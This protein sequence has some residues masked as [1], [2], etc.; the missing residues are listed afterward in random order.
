MC[1][2]QHISLLIYGLEVPPAVYA[3]TTSAL[4]NNDGDESGQTCAYCSLWSP[5]VYAEGW[6]CLKPQC[7][8]FWDFPGR[9]EAPMSLSYSL[10]FLQPIELKLQY[11]LEDL[12]PPLPVDKTTHGGVGATT[13]RHFYKGWHCRNCGR[14][15]SRCVCYASSFEVT[16]YYWIRYKWEHWECKHCGVSCQFCLANMPLINVHL[17]ENI[18][19][20]G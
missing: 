16:K 14:L 10:P 9:N 6:T 15:S 17:L 4:G 18:H 7:F 2:M 19:R 11:E 13:S 5:Q 12:R 20:T 1:S 3:G 8:S